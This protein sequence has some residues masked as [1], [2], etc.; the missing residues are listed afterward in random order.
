MNYVK[1]NPLKAI[2]QTILEVREVLAILML[3]PT[4]LSHTLMG[5]GDENLNMHKLT[6]TRSSIPH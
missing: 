5:R 6:K 2:S 1:P 4:A 3:V